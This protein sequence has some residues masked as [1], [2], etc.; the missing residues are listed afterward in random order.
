MTAAVE[1]A[2]WVLVAVLDLVVLLREVDPVAAAP[3]VDP[4]AA[5]VVVRVAVQPVASAVLAAA[6]EALHRTAMIWLPI[7][8]DRITTS[9][10]A[11]SVMSWST[12]N[13]GESSSA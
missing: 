5:S 2:V 12:I 13:R 9:V 8:D 10:I 4:V 6:E 11:S 1:A 3:E 7:G